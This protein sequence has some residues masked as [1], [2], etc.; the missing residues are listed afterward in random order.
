MKAMSFRSLLGGFAATL[1]LGLSGGAWSE[2]AWGKG[3]RPASLLKGPYLT[4]LSES[5][6]SVRFELDGPASVEV[7]VRPDGADAG[8]L[9][10]I[11]DGPAVMH[12]VRV[13]GLAPARSYSYAV[14]IAG[15]A[16][17]D[18]RFSTAP[19]PDSAAPLKFLVYGDNRS[20]P[21]TH[22]AVVRALAAASSDFV[23]NTGDMVEDG[24]RAEDWQSF[25]DVEARLLRRRPIFV[26]IGNHELYDDRAGANFAR[27][28]GFDQS[29]TPR[30]Y[31]TVRLSNVR[32]FFLNSMHDWASG[33]ERQW[34]ERELGRVDA[35]P[36]VVW[37]IAVMHQGPWSGGPH[38]GSA[39]LNRGHVPE[40]LRAHHVDL[41]FSGH[42]HIYERGESGGIKYVVSGGGGSPLYGVSKIATT[43]KAEAAYHY[44][45]VATS[46]DDLR[47]V[48]RRIDGSILDQCGFKGGSSW[49]CDGPS[50]GRSEAR[51]QTKNQDESAR[52]GGALGEDGSFSA[53]PLSSS[54]SKRDPAG[55][56]GCGCPD[57]GARRE[58]AGFIVCALLL[59]AHRRSR[60]TR[61]EKLPL[62]VSGERRAPPTVRPEVLRLRQP[63]ACAKTTLFLLAKSVRRRIARA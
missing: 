33:D 22:A 11:E 8:G 57:A 26:A 3:P 44:L 41:V 50:A 62:G 49:D 7:E 42:D 55:R 53:G 37:R 6:V 56:C 15:S 61:R 19:A 5:G 47:L 14:F 25:F 39:L 32:L 27:Y 54:P 58:S 12:V 48:A 30:P 46:K 63:A 2:P 1:V 31:G 18:G 10:T 28:F 38:G 9:A 59:A 16:V 20:D 36:G 24:G 60:H 4:D 52:P 34:L 29:G 40:L 45:E 43:R 13:R 35:E 23:V 51:E 21:V 17:G